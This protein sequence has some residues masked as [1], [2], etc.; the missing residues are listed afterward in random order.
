MSEKAGAPARKVLVHERPIPE[1]P[2]KDG[3]YVID[4]DFEKP[5]YALE[6]EGQE[7]SPSRDGAQPR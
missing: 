2:G 6:D 7:P 1:L 5:I 4:R 3:D